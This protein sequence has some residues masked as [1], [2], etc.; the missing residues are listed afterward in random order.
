MIIYLVIQ[1]VL[2]G[3][4]YTAGTVLGT[5]DTVG[6]TPGLGTNPHGPYNVVGETQESNL[7]NKCIIA[8]VISTVN[9]SQVL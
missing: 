6:S 5:A 8:S 3:A 2:L 9:K 7:T 4:C 1:I